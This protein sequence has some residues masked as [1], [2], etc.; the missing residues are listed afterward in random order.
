M[1][2][3]AEK[4]NSDDLIEVQDEPGMEERFQPGHQPGLNMPPQRRQAPVRKPKERPAS[5]GRVHKGK[6]R[7]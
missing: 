3:M 4:K 2:S 7:N 5:K 6:S 1:P